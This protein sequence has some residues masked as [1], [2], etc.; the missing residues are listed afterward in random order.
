MAP[1]IAVAKSGEDPM[2]GL[3]ESF[4]DGIIG[5]PESI[6]RGMRT[7]IGMTGV[8]G[9]GQKHISDFKNFL[10]FLSKVPFDSAVHRIAV[11]AV[12]YVLEHYEDA[13]LRKAAHTLGSVVTKRVIIQQCV[14]NVTN[15]A[16]TAAASTAV[17]FGA[18]SILAVFTVA[19]FAGQSGEAADRL[20]RDIPGLADILEKDGLIGGYF[21]IEDAINELRRNL[22]YA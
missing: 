10:S 21:L 14:N 19:D 13:L 1:T 7:I 16:N 3:L 6:A 8:T 2:S 5:T 18:R 17:K 22:H 12:P 15:A 20:R 9:A 4:V 11:V